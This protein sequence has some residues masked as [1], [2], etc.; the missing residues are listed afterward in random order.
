MAVV[1]AIVNVGCASGPD[2]HPP[3]MPEA[4]ARSFVSQPADTDAAASLPPHWWKLYND[5]ALDN[6]VQEALSANTNLRVTLANLDR[7]R[8][9]YKEARGGLF[10][11]TNV[12]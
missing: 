11:S 2:Y 4:A 1:A 10:P 8:A 7:A 3:A 12:S 9:I 6:L 5:P